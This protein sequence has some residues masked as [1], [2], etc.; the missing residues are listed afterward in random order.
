MAAELSEPDAEARRRAAKHRA[1]RLGAWAA[2]VLAALGVVLAGFTAATL[3][4]ASRGAA[5][6]AEVRTVLL[7]DLIY[8]IALAALVIWTIGKAI[9]ARRARSAGSKLH[10]RLSGIFTL[11]ALAPTVLVAVF[12]TLTVNFGME[13]WFSN[14][15][16]SVV[17]NA[18]E[19][20][21]AYATEHRGNI[22]GDALAMANDI[23]R[24][25]GVIS[26]DSGA[27]GELVRQQAFLRELPEAY[28]LDGSGEILARGEFSYLFTLDLP[29]P[30]QFAAARAGEVVVI[31]DQDKNEMRALVH[32]TGLIDGYL[33]ISRR[34]EGEILQL[35][36]ETR[37][38]VALY[39]RLERE[40]DTVL[41]DFALLYLGFAVVVI[42]AAVWLGLWFAGRLA[43]PIGRLAGAAELVGAGDFDARVKEPRGDDEIALLSRVFNRMTAQVKQQR[44][45][46]LEANRE[47][48][49]RRL[50]LQTVLS[51]V[52]AGVV[53]LD[54]DGRIDLVN[55]AALG[56]LGVERSAAEGGALSDVV[57]ALSPL[58]QRAAR[59]VGGMA[60]EQLRLRRGGAERELLWR[61]TPKKGDPAAGAVVTIDDLTDL[62]QAQRMAAWG[63][64]ARRIAHEIKNPLTP[65]QLSADRL[66]RKFEKMPVEDRE[67]LSQYAD[68]ISR[69][70]GD[71][72]RMVDEFARFARMPE[73]Q[74]RPEDLGALLEAAVLLQ[75]EGANGVRWTLDAPERPVMARCDRGLMNQALVNLMKNAAEAIEGRLATCP[76]GP[77]GEVRVALREGP[78]GAA[79][80]IADNGAGL[81][82]DR[83]RL[84]EPYVTTRARGTGLGLAIVKKI[85]EQ[86][87]GALTL[88]DAPPFADGAPPGAL[89]RLCLPAVDAKAAPEPQLRAS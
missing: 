10:L 58:L 3:D 70:A 7:I 11:V 17:R 88:T 76:G 18:L 36:D 23:N 53:G 25:S 49:R 84:M 21:E 28:V 39:E 86:H 82:E 5:T 75:R 16:R 71:I 12:A 33:Y 45:A 69:Q 2:G 48:E 63:D 40:R 35:L 1:R 9:A 44:D 14:Q 47:T 15:V 24:A 43:K 79:I 4:R 37:E 73:P 27:L 34:V 54:S 61:I 38:T 31:D 19:T 65:I 67:A 26:I 57:P 59:S 80:E 66:K 77:P 81:P 89:A 78:D 68:V 42:L 20:A 8:I 83:S 6:P 72:R 60:Q 29:A 51:G 13:A 64:V 52:S 30:A 55:D 22:V 46:L 56:M 41:F 74:T 50:L 85:V 62:V 87:G 32:L